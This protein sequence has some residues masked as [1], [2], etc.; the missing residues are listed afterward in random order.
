MPEFAGIPSPLICFGEMLSKWI[1]IRSKRSHLENEK[2]FQGFIMFSR[3]VC[4]PQRPDSSLRPYCNMKQSLFFFK[5][6][7]H[8]VLNRWFSLPLWN[9]R[10]YHM[11]TLMA[12]LSS[13]FHAILWDNNLENIRKPEKVRWAM[14]PCS[15]I[16]SYNHLCN[17]WFSA[18]HLSVFQSK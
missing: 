6:I 10:I 9:N 2:Q 11:E 7:S 13:S 16:C 18:K 8:Y 12:A 3:V 15:C 14:S 17:D 1:H 5:R 4:A